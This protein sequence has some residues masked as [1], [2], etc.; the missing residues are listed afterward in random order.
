MAATVKA[1]ISASLT[2]QF[3]TQGQQALVGLSAWVDH[4]NQQGGLTVGGEKRPVTLVRYDDGSTAEATRR[5]TEQLITGDQVDLLFGPYSA[6]LTTAA[7]E[8]AET[9][10]KVVWEPGRRRRR[11][12]RPG[13]PQ[14]DQRADSGRPIPGRGAGVGPP[15]EPRGQPAG[16][17]ADRHGRFR[18]ARGSWCGNCGSRAGVH[19]GAGPALPADAGQFHRDRPP[20]GRTGTGPRGYRGAHPPRYW[21]RPGRWPGSRTATISAWPPLSRHPSQDSKNCWAKRPTGSWVRANGNRP[22]AYQRP[23][24]GPALPKRCG[25]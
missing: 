18:Q 9:H 25:Y 23:T 15:G 22:S 1:G 7:A 20:R 13:V 6:G 17:T 16:Y 8:V 19:H 4:V 2:G 21:G 11:A 14:G 10:G 24:W 12:L 5:A 3:A